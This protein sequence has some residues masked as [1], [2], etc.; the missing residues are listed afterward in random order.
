MQYGQNATAY[1]MLIHTYSRLGLGDKMIRLVKAGREKFSDP[2]FMALDMGNYYRSRQNIE[3]ALIE[4]LTFAQHNPRQH[5]V[6]MDKL[7][8]ISDDQETLPI[9]EKQLL[10]NK[11]ISADFSR[12]FLAAFYFKVGRYE[13]SLQQQLEINGD[14][15]TRWK[16]LNA[17]AVNLRQ[18]KQYGLATKT[19]EI[20]MQEIRSNPKKIEAKELG[21]VLLGLG[22]VYE[23][24]IMPHQISNSLILN[25]I[26]NVFFSSSYYQSSNISSASLEQ[27]ITLYN[28]ILHELEATSFSPQAHFRLGEIQFK[29]LQ[30]LDGA[31][32]AYNAALLSNPNQK[33][34]FK[35]HASMIDLLISEGKINEAQSYIN[36]LPGN[37]IAGNE[38]KLLIK[39]LKI[40][41]FNGEMDSSIVLL[42]NY[43]LYLVPIEKH[44]NDFMELQAS[45]HAHVTDGNEEDKEAFLNYLN[46]EK[47]IAQDKLSEAV[48]IFANMRVNQPSSKITTTAAIREIFSRLQ[49]GQTEEM[50]QS[51]QWLNKS[52][53]GDKG[54]VL[55]GE[56]AEFID[57]NTAAALG[58]YEQLLQE[59]PESLLVEPI[60]HRIRK[61]KLNLES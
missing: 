29:V 22:Q 24:Q 49:L 39:S 38:S 23:D 15:H 40:M 43:L 10:I 32:Q 27:A 55:S 14:Q 21:K 3:G 50:N 59:Y 8:I 52:N 34:T 31:R 30:D 57:Q 25:T 51:L 53:D 1:R 13:E 2:D 7:L 18:E 56:I 45:L 4:Y 33:L 6:I 28:T 61:L 42:N 37:I 17:F 20:L 19:Y 41:L 46:G 48:N 54:L 44:F 35:I 12:S 36:Q 9:I 11:D 47:L 5:K 26:N 60:R 16:G 58:F